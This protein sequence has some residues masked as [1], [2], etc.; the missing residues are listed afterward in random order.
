MTDLQRVVT[1]RVRSEHHDVVSAI[2]C[3]ADDVAHA[4]PADCVTDRQAVVVPMHAALVSSGVFER[5]P[6]VLLDLVRHAGYDLQ[7]DPVA[8]PPYVV[9][10][11]RGPLLRATLSAGRLLVRFVAFEIRRNPE[12]VYAR[13]D[14]ISIDVSLV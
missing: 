6:D 11:S 13:R 3:A 5:L 4:W 2:D 14:D 12:P 7:A 1:D 10:T 9:L 8:A